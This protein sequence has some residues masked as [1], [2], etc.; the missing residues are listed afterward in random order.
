MRKKEKKPTA[1][2]ARRRL[3][4]I[5]RIKSFRLELIIT[6]FCLMLLACGVLHSARTPA[7]T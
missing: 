7:C 6:I 2:R 3:R 5:L 1:E 4:G